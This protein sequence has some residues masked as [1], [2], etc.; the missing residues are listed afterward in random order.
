MLVQLRVRELVLIEQLDVQL[1]PGFNVLTGETGAGK[2]LVVAAFD[3]LLGRRA[4]AELVRRGAAEAEVEGL[5]DVSDEPAVRERL[6]AAGLPSSG[7]LL[8]RRVVPSDGRNRCYVNGKL[9][10]LA[11]LA[12]LAAGLASVMGQHEH[13][14]LFDPAVQLALLDAYGVPKALL[15]EMAAR[16]EALRAAAST[17][18][19]LAA[20]ERDRAARLDY[21]R[22]QLEEIDRLSPEPDELDRIEREV[23]LLR[24]QGVLLETA[25]RGAHD[26]YEADGSIF[27]RLGALS[28]ALEDAA[29][30]D[31]SLAAEARQ[32]G[33]AVVLVEEAARTL[34]SYGRGAEAEPGRLEELEERREALRRLTR[35]H[36]TE[37][38]GVLAVRE[39]LAAE[40]RALERYEDSMRDA[41]AAL[42]IARKEAEETAAGLSR[43]R[44][45]A[46]RRFSAA[47]TAE[48]ADL[49][50][51]K[52]ACDARLEELPL[53]LGPRG[54]DALEL[55]VS[56]N[57]GEGAH[58]L[59]KVASGGELSRVMLAVR[60]VL[61]GLGPVGTYVFDEVDA[62]IGGGV[63]TAV[64]R[65]LCDVAAH[66]QVICIT[67]LP[68]IAAMADA[69]LCVSKT[70]HGGRTLTC[71]D[72]LGAAERVEEIARMLGGEHVTSK[73]RSAARELLMGRP[74]GE[75]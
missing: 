46:A 3:L 38:A 12:D 24:H 4:S 36:G 20:A 1:A 17:R 15:D 21:A 60:R 41:E 31:E 57:P 2:S 28:R 43:K 49:S 53:A 72:R 9:A 11:V 70:E 48:L 19:G 34:G 33:D 50:F 59:R 5:F 54:R 65:K 55:Y 39:R 66:H 44:R 47:V 27:E 30:H 61:A 58:P 63:A 37:L 73:I 32:I 74:A 8:V 7:E 68:Q 16:H 14:A 29:K 23:K 22:F 42:S 45:E 18:D 75:R 56:L 6:E 13:H 25:R 62:G 71:V 35:K 67:H 26:L 64:G 51:A 40:V 69:H 52:A 10:S